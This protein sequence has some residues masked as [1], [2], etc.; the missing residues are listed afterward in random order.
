MITTF[1]FAQ[2]GAAKKKEEIKQGLKSEAKLTDDQI[3]S[4]MVIE[5]QFRPKIKAIKADQ[6]LNEKAKKEKM[7]G[8]GVEKKEKLESVLG[9]DVAKRVEAFYAGQ[10]KNKSESKATNR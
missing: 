1:A 10:K 2:G 3:E 9:K 8:V 4:V 6:T 5:Q 7:S